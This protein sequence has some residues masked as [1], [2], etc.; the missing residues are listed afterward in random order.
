MAPDDDAARERLSLVRPSPGAPQRG[1][2]GSRFVLELA[3]GS[4]A[5]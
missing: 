1:T 3:M 4:F 2:Y 5:L